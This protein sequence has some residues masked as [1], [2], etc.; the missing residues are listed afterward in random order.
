MATK[1]N[2]VFP[3]HGFFV[4]RCDHCEGQS[5]LHRI[6][7]ALF[8]VAAE[9]RENLQE[10]HSVKRDI[11][12]VFPLFKEWSRCDNACFCYPKKIESP[13]FGA[14]RRKRVILDF[15]Q[16]GDVPR[17][18]DRVPQ[19]EERAARQGG[20]SQGRGNWHLEVFVLR[21]RLRRA[22]R[23]KIPFAQSWKLDNMQLIFKIV[24]SFFKL[25]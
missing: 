10:S 23:R 20:A 11:G 14:N 9:G 24:A 1:S 18:G 3:N 22:E 15:R 21:K 19:A 7:V 8:F 16:A 12:T 6:F 17:H 2:I 13:S 5:R 4:L 25:D